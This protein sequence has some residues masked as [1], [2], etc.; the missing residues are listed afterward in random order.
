M[1]SR[2]KD[3]ERG[4]V[5]DAVAI[6]GVPPRTVQDLAARG[7]LPGAAKFGRRWTFDLSKLRRYVRE[8]ER[9]T[10][11][12]GARLQPGVTGVVIPSGAALK[13]TAMRSDGRFTQVIQRLRARAAKQVKNA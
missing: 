11:N 8:K 10:W 7:E 9:T 6:L 4:I 12:E 5:A 1:S 3:L 2:H 13:S